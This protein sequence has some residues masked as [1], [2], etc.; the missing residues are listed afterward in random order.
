M[1]RAVQDVTASLGD[2]VFSNST[3]R[4]AGARLDTNTA[5]LPQLFCPFQELF[6]RLLQVPRP[7]YTGH[8]WWIN[9]R[10]FSRL[11]PLSVTA[12]E[13]CSLCCVPLYSKSGQY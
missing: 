13:P 1:D 6:F 7:I 2:C 3:G 5:N 8:S 10:P 12:Q 4:F 9:L 11:P